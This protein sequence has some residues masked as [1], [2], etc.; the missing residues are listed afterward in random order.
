MAK[1]VLLKHDLPDGCWH[2][3]WL[4]ERP[5]DPGGP[6]LAL[7]VLERI[8][9]LAQGQFQAERIPD[10]RQ[11]YLAFEGEVSDGR[12]IVKRLATGEC[13]CIQETPD[14]LIVEAKFQ[15][16][17]HTFKGTPQ[18]GSATIYFSVSDQSA[19]PGG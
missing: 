9:T 4:I 15:G 18:P 14:G 6:L 19:A 10:H 1:M 12:G 13:S 7:R 2:Y 5:Q 16:R 3:D 11:H 17:S 8:D